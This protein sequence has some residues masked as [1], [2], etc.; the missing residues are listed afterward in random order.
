MFNIRHSIIIFLTFVVISHD[1]VADKVIVIDDS[2]LTVELTNTTQKIVSLSPHLTELTYEAGAEQYLIATVEY[3]DY[4]K[5][6]TKL[7]RVGSFKAWDMEKIISLNPDV[8]LVWQSGGNQRQIDQLYEL[9]LNVY[10]SEPRQLSDISKTIRDI[11]KMAGTSLQAERKAL[12]FDQGINKIKET[13][14][15][16]SPVRLFYQVWGE[17]LITI[18]GQQLMSQ[19][20]HI[21][22]GINIFSTLKTLAPVI[23]KEALLAENPDVIIGGARP[24]DQIN[25]LDEWKRW[26]EMKAVKN[27]HLFYINPDLLNRQTTRMLQGAEK[28]CDVLNQVR[29]N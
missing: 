14:Q 9:G 25:W 23:T 7:P 12:A 27:N 4:P 22:G 13:F 3:S 1:A 24:E 20:F 26:S 10:I 18:N 17:P 8:I 16:L 28:V 21:C 11:G 5:A 6:A 29:G 19:V 2:N 15:H